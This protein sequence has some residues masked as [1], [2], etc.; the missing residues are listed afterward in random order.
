MRLC[1]VESLLFINHRIKIF[2]LMLTDDDDDDVVDHPDHD[3]E[4]SL[5]LN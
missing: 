4:F 1:S 3:D 5:Y 2:I